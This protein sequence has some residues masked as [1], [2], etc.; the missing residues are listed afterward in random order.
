[1]AT[2]GQDGSLRIMAQ[3]WEG[4]RMPSGPAWT[5]VAFTGKKWPEDQLNFLEACAGFSGTAQSVSSSGNYGI[6]D[7][8]R[9]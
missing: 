3:S 4:D 1:M 9:G 6:K 8:P 5:R 2:G 7:H